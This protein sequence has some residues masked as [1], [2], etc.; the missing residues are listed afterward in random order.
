M[1]MLNVKISEANYKCFSNH[2]NIKKMTRAGDALA[3][4]S[5]LASSSAARMSEYGKEYFQGVPVITGAMTK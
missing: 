1:I 2:N 4:S 3:S 5:G